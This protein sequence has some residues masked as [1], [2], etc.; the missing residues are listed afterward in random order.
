M[1]REKH[2]TNVKLWFL[3][4]VCLVVF[5]GLASPPRANAQATGTING[6]VRDSTG[7]VIPD[8]TVVLHAKATNLDQTTTT[9]SVGAYVISQIHPGEYSLKVT[10]T[11]FRTE[12]TNLSLNVNQTAAVDLVLT[13]G[14]TQETVEVQATSAALETST[15]EL[16]EAIVKSQVNDLPLNGRNFTQLLNLTPG[17]SS[18]NV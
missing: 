12:V 5:A 15:S 17:V 7:A 11:G 6:T 3:G 16:G 13:T 10:K 8:A 14:S 2:P 1:T 9:N 18:V 4:F